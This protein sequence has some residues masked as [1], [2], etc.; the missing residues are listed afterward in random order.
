MSVESGDSFRGA[1]VR[2]E[3]STLAFPKISSPSSALCTEQGGEMATNERTPQ[4]SR[5]LSTELNF[6]N[7]AW[8][9]EQRTE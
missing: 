4:F 9:S 3:F 2:D 1:K 5:M 7:S 6:V 8:N